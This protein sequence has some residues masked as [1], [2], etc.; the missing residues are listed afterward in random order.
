MVIPSEILSDAANL[1][2]FLDGLFV[3]GPIEGQIEIYAVDASKLTL[4]RFNF[5]LKMLESMDR[6]YFW[7]YGLSFYNYPKT[8]MSRCRSI[9]NVDGSTLVADFFAELKIKGNFPKVP[10]YAVY[11]VHRSPSLAVKM[12]SVISRFSDF[13]FHLD[14]MPKD[15]FNTAVSFAKDFGEEHVALL[16]EWLMRSPIF[17]AGT[18][19]LCPFLRKSGID[20]TLSPRFLFPFLVAK[21][22]GTW[23]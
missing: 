15:G 18:L 12:L 6:V 8:I 4:L 14:A 1:R 20:L 19:A 2:L 16:E 5:F 10:H 23:D 9:K 7:F 17:P 3:M 13:L 22:F 11:L 21:K